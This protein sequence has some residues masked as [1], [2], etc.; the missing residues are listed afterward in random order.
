MDNVESIINTTHILDIDGEKFPIYHQDRRLYKFV[1]WQD[2][3][4]KLIKIM[5][6]RVKK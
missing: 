6:V 3:R 5:L 1:D 2:A 4:N